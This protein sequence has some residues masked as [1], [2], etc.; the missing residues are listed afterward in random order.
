MIG[1][2]CESATDTPKEVLAKSYVRMVSLMVILKD[3]AYRDVAEIS[4]EEVLEYMKHD[5]PKT[6][7]PQYGDTYNAFEDLVKSGYKE[8]FGVTIS[9]GISGT[10]NLF[11]NIANDIKKKYPDVNIKIIDSRNISIG[12][13]LI[14]YKISEMIDENQTFEYIKS[15]IS[16]SIG[17][18]TNVFFL[19]PTLT[20]LKANGRIGK[21]AASVGTFLNIKPIISVNEEGMYYDVAKSRGMKESVNKLMTVF[22]SWVGKRTIHAVGIYKSG[23]SDQT[24][25]Y[26]KKVM[27]R[28][29]EMEPKYIFEGQISSVALVHTGDGL[30]GIAAVLD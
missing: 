23:N 10:Y 30:V 13:G 20:Y 4:H 12:A 24:N 22:E 25:E 18:R 16:D 17:V 19:V 8:I 11:E 7:S 26:V 2:V 29:K 14:T 15:K 9:S 6:S 28:I 21:I 1:L 5:I 3:K 27:N